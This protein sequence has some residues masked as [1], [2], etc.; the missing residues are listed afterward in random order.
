MIRS[1]MIPNLLATRYG[2]L[3]A[4]FFLYLT[5]GIPLGFTATAIATQMRRQGLSPSEIG[6]FVGTLYLPWAWKW[7]VGPVVDV[8]Y[9]ERIGRRR[10]WILAMQVLM[11][12]GLIAIMRIN[13][14]TE[15]ALFTA[16]VMVINALGATQDVAI[17]AL[18]VGVLHESERGTANGIMFAGAY[19]GAAIG[20]SGVLLLTKF[21]SFN[22]AFVLMAG[23]ILAVTVFV[24]LP[25]R[26]SRTIAPRGPG[27]PGGEQEGIIRALQSYVVVAGRSIFGS[28]PA[29]AGL[30]FAILP[31]GALGL[32]LSLGTNLAVEL[33]M[34]DAKIGAT[35]L[36]STII[37][38]IA[39]I[40]GGYLS[41][42]LGRKKMLAMYI[43]GMVATTFYFA[44]IMKSYGWIMPADPRA[45]DPAIVPG[46]L[47]NSYIIVGFVFAMFMGLM[48]G[49][50]TALF[51]DI[52]NPAVAATQF[53]AYMAV[54]NLV[55]WY[56]S[57]WQGWALER[58]GYPA[59]L[60]ADGMLGLLGLAVLPFMKPVVKRVIALQPEEAEAAAASG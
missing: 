48:Y 3:T 22:S 29:I 2:R 32:S 33:G 27:A 17:D 26:E 38:A 25:M 9:W 21:I 55:I 10:G 47:V 12:I 6:V 31:A 30:V 11:S 23:C 37:S 1:L 19:V 28:G 44:F 59:T 40:V 15:L 54:L 8:V 41:D 58:W 13:F 43:A 51:M 18:A 20:G 14:T 46:A 4:F 60:M 5:E 35:K 53:T 16:L 42:R 36:I 52:C 45:L 34:S 24:V 57:T 7:M 50:R 56:S 39:C 49:T